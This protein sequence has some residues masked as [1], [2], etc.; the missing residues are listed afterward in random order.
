[1]VPS[2]ICVLSITSASLGIAAMIT[3]ASGSGFLFMN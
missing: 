3:G 2:F 1:M